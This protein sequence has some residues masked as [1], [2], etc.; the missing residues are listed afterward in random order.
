MLWLSPAIMLAAEPDLI[1]TTEVVNNS[2]TVCGDE[3][4]VNVNVKN[5]TSN[6]ITLNGLN[7][8]NPAVITNQIL[9]TSIPPVLGTNGCASGYNYCPLN[10]LSIAKAQILTLVFKVKTDCSIISQVESG[11][12]NFFDVKILYN[13]SLVASQLSVNS[14]NVLYPNY[15][16]SIQ[17]EGVVTYGQTI[18]RT[19][20]VC[21]L[22]NGF[23]PNITISHVHDPSLQWISTTYVINAPNGTTLPGG[24]TP[25]F[26]TPGNT[27]NYILTD[28]NVESPSDPNDQKRCYVITEKYKVTSCSGKINSTYTANW[29]CNNVY[30]KSASATTSL[31]LKDQFAQLS[32][33]ELSFTRPSFCIPGKI[34]Y[35]INNYGDDPAGNI[36]FD[37]PYTSNV[38][39]TNGKVGLDNSCGTSGVTIS[40]AS[41]YH[42]DI[43]ALTGLANSSL[44][45]N[46][47]NG[48]IFLDAHKSIYVCFDVAY[49]CPAGGGDVVY[50][51]GKATLNYTDVCGVVKPP[52]TLDMNETSVSWSTCGAT[53][54]PDMAID[55]FKN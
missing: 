54:K 48:R 17:P 51:I 10:T 22:G 24:G 21:N 16:I 13:T 37:L 19:I 5:N 33:K 39:L 47:I 4:T 46:L 2:I 43:S 55:G 14:V 45:T 20:T 26:P 52:V 40:P 18:T 42:I 12:L 15:S 27:D 25:T 7:L 31:V 38:S 29:G 30:C 9:V 53:F 35:E 8:F 11:K 49:T 32:L 1:I 28:N 6:P 3:V 50:D 44:G 41:P 36:L 34:V 23:N